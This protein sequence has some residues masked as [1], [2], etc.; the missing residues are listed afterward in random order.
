MSGPRPG[1]EE[2][3]APPL[4]IYRQPHAISPV[5]EGGE[6]EDDICC[7]FLARHSDSMNTHHEAPPH[8]LLYFTRSL[9]DTQTQTFMAQRAKLWSHSGITCQPRQI[10][11]ECRLGGGD[12]TTAQ[13]SSAL[14]F[15]LCSLHLG[16]QL[17][18]FLSTAWFRES[19][20]ACPLC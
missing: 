8:F 11:S 9:S 16:T 14:H 15:L 10:S 18:R 13:P 6:E 12:T 3:S 1:V 19:G 5:S 20:M 2:T 7:H 4:I 17:V